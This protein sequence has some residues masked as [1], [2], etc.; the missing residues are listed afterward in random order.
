MY[1]N[2]ESSL[3]IYGNDVEPREFTEIIGILPTKAW[4]KGEAYYCKYNGRTLS[5]PNGLWQYSPAAQV[6]SFGPE[7]MARELLRVFGGKKNAFVKIHQAW[8]VE[9]S[10]WIAWTLTF[11]TYYLD[12]GLIRRMLELGIDTMA[13]CFIGLSGGAKISPRNR[14]DRRV[15]IDYELERQNGEHA[16]TF[17]CISGNDIDPEECTSSMGLKPSCTWKYGDEYCLR[18]G[19][20][21][22]LRDSSLWKYE[23]SLDEFPYE[24]EKQVESLV[25][26][27]WGKRHVISQIRKGRDSKIMLGIK[28]VAPHGTYKLNRALLRRILDIGIDTIAYSYVCCEVNEDA[29]REVE[30]N[31]EDCI[32]VRFGRLL[33]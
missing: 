8:N 32:L 10:A 7:D 14:Y 6:S 29:M 27:L 20:K 31:K 18:N 4:K 24:P 23:V 33:V 3:S 16:S 26:I 21:K 1:K 15:G 12:R 13:H 11:G 22:L 9:V 2:S 30:E 17:L 25:R 28:W 5:R 19:G